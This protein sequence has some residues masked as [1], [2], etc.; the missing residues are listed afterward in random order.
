MWTW[1]HAWIPTISSSSLSSSSI[2]YDDDVWIVFY[3]HLLSKIYHGHYTVGGQFGPHFSF[4]QINTLQAIFLYHIL[5]NEVFAL[6]QEAGIPCFH[7]V[8]AV[9]LQQWSI[10]CYISTD[11]LHI[12]WVVWSV[13]TML[14]NGESR[15]CLTWLVLCCRN[16]H[17]LLHVQLGAKQADV[18]APG[19]WR[20]G[21]GA[22]LWQAGHRRSP[23]RDVHSV[24][25]DVSAKYVVDIQTGRSVSLVSPSVSQLF[26]SAS[27]RL[28]P[29]ML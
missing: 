5:N 18:R 22:G 26:F 21:P 8:I 15:D 2:I 7:Y 16:G 3:F 20:V 11:L 10:T 24:Q 27:Q 6:L 9:W 4:V 1:P 19:R 17:H 23:Q 29:L 12:A 14:W 28:E 25:E 13:L